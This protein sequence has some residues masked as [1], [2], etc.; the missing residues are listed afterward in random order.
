MSEHRRRITKRRR[1]FSCHTQSTS[2]D[3]R[4]IVMSMSVCLSVTCLCV[5]TRISGTARPIFAKFPT[6][7]VA[8]AILIRRSCDSLST[9]GLWM[10]SI[11]DNRPYSGDGS[12]ASAQRELNTMSSSDLTTRYIRSY[13][14][15]GSTRP[16]RSLLSTTALLLLML[17]INAAKYNHRN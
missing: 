5:R 12:R 11:V 1:A 13:S 9:S 16:G 10:T 7:R 3:E 14:A 15:D 6:L 2:L 8:V 4:S 17:L